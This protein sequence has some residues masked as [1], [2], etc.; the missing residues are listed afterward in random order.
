M[1]FRLISKSNPRYCVL[2]VAT[3]T[4]FWFVTFIHTYTY[5]YTYARTHTHTHTHANL[6]FAIFWN[7]RELHT[8]AITIMVHKIQYMR[9]LI[10]ILKT[11][12]LRK[13]SGQI[14]R[15]K[16]KYLH[17]LI[18]MITKNARWA[19]SFLVKLHVSNLQ[20]Y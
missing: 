16:L 3:I 7:D 11:S 12:D 8:Q 20:L 5:T 19:N 13:H 4:L 2:H 9:N 15:N 10:F 18:K 1:D 6:K 14:E 17:Y